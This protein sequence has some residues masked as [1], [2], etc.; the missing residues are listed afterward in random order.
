MCGTF[1]YWMARWTLQPWFCRAAW[2]SSVVT[3]CTVSCTCGEP[4]V[5]AH[6]HPLPLRSLWLEQ[7]GTE[8]V[9]IS[10][11]SLGSTVSLELRPSSSPASSASPGLG[12][13]LPASTDPNQ[14]AQGDYSD[15][16]LP[17]PTS[18]WP[19]AKLICRCSD[20]SQRKSEDSL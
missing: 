17:P 6:H 1:R 20:M 18:L 9:P 2:H 12:C 10:A 19:W 8:G 11:L 15:S 16:H 5:S 13:A 4:V 3:P 14:K 7:G